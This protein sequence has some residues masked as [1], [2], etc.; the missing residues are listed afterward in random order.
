A[1]GCARSSYLLLETIKELPGQFLGCA[2]QQACAHAG[3]SPADHD[4]RAPI[5]PRLLGIYSSRIHGARELNGAAW[6]FA[7]PLYHHQ[8]GLT[9]LRSRHIKSELGLDRSDPDGDNSLPM[10]RLQFLQALKA[11]SARSHFIDI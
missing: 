6:R 4:M 2:L 8:F 11:R 3:N 10:F 1:C 7:T 9:H 5:H